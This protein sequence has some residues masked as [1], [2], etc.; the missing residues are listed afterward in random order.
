[1]MHKQKKCAGVLFQ[2]QQQKNNY[3]LLQDRIELQIIQ[4]R[5]KMNAC[6]G[7]KL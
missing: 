3:D 7:G 6:S 2:Q 1:M 4:V 5:R